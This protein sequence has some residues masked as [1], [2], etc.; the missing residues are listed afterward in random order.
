MV[1]YDS[2][3]AGNRKRFGLPE[4]AFVCLFIFDSL[5]YMARKNPLAHVR[6][7]KQAFAQNENAV[8]LIKTMNR[9]KTDA[10]LWKELISEMEGDA[11]IHLINETMEK[12][13][14]LSL[15][16][17][18]DVYLSLHRSEGFGRTIAEAMLYG[19]PVV[20]SAYSGNLDFCDE[21]NACLVPGSLIDVGEDQ[22]PWSEDCVWFDPDVSAAAGYLRKLFH[23]PA[24]RQGKGSAGQATMQRYRAD[25]VYEQYIRSELELIELERSNQFKTA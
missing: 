2:L 1:E 12:G 6:A 11:R 4:D 7:F 14:L 23:E 21:S 17:A 5:S 24:L 16:G 20:V 9:D 18:V 25:A 3:P 19:R 10:S 13:A 8:L 22:Y 15:Y